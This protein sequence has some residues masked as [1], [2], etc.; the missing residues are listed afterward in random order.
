[1]RSL[2]QS[3]LIVPH[4][5][6]PHHCLSSPAP[7][8]ALRHAPSQFLINTS[9]YVPLDPPAPTKSILRLHHHPP[10]TSCNKLQLCT[11]SIS[12]SASIQTSSPSTR[13]M[14]PKLQRPLMLL[15]ASRYLILDSSSPG[16][17]AFIPK[18]MSS[19]PFLLP[20]DVLRDQ[21]PR[22]FDLSLSSKLTE[23]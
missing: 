20:G 22:V 6:S 16:F 1:M 17:M 2:D 11:L 23:T 15:H 7:A 9:P 14:H 21:L 4:L 18:T 8:P 3:R 13:L 12:L 10:R 19:S 5:P